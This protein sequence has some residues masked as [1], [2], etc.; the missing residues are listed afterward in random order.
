MT[1]QGAATDAGRMCP[2]DYRYSPEVFDRPPDLRAE[3]LYVVGGLYGNRAALDV[4]EEMAARETQPATIVFNGDFHWF[5]AEPRWF[6][7]IADRVAPYPA[8]RGNIETEIARAD[9][10]GAGCGCAY[11]GN[12]SGEVVNWSNT[13]MCELRDIVSA[14]HA[15]RLGALPMHLVAAVGGLR[16]GIVHGDATSL[17]GWDFAHDRLADV[18]GQQQMAAL[19]RASTIDVFASTHTCLA[20]L[21]DVPAPNR[22]T[23]I[24]NGAAGMPNFS[25]TRFGV[26]TR[27]ATGLSPHQPVY[28]FKRD[29]V[30]IDAL[31]VHYDTDAF[32]RDFA[33]RW[34][35]GS[36]AS[37]S[38]LRRILRGPDHSIEAAV[39]A[40]NIAAA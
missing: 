21:C 34:P 28:G 4:I 29:G 13:I 18:E 5:D 27:I 26:I 7:A 9:D 37:L 6:A 40:P 25:G 36:P 1:A 14:E 38:Y 3:V 32:L 30:F 16:V 39:L 19:H 24:N 11:P 17:A 20:A 12:V 22:L 10:I 8:L 33:A 2:R 23:V 35:E 31:A 15:A